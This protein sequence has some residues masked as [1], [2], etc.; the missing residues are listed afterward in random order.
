MRNPFRRRNAVPRLKTPDDK[1]SLRDHLAELRVRIVRC[2]LAITLGFVVILIFYDD[3]LSFLTKPYRNLCEKGRLEV[4]D[5]ATCGRLISLTPLDG[6]GARISICVYGGIIAATPVITWQIW[7]FVSPALHKHERRYAVPFIASTVG[8]FLLGCL[9][10]YLT[11]QPALNFLID[12]GRV[13]PNFQVSKYVSFVGL[14]AAAFGIGFQFPVLLVFLQLVGVLN[15]RQLL[16]WWRYATVVIV[17]IAAAIT[18]SGDPISLIALGV[19]MLI[20][21]YVSILIGYFLAKRKAKRAAP[22]A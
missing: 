21:Y 9:L 1:M 18:P 10:A 5:A 4:A 19:P 16:K 13:E 11:L 15:W 6:F 2:V 20:F 7:R 8:L 3:I 17:F 12:F 22:A 14:M